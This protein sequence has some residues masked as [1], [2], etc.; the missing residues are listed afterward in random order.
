MEL[1]G[2]KLKEKKFYVVFQGI[3]TGIF[4]SWEKCAPYVLDCR[5]S[6]YKSF[7]TEEEAKKAYDMYSQSNNYEDEI[8]SI[9][10]GVNFAVEPSKYHIN[11][12]TEEKKKDAGLDV[13]CELTLLV[14][15]ELLI[16][17]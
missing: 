8:L 15:I 16:I 7:P 5:G 17:D 6:L 13:T 4:S 10:H 2:R 12:V 9:G 3:R 14:K 11:S 1:K